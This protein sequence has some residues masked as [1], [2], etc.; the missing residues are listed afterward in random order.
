MGMSFSVYV[1]PMAVCQV[2]KI[3][4]VFEDQI[5]PNTECEQHKLTDN[6][7]PSCGTAASTHSY[8]LEV[9]PD[10]QDMAIELDDALWEISRE[11][12]LRD[13]AYHVPNKKRAGESLRTTMFSIGADTAA[14]TDLP[15][16]EETAWFKSAFEAE[17]KILE[18]AYG[19]EN[20]E[21][22]WGVYPLYS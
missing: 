20:V 5:C 21:I 19:S 4:T 7:C 18:K 9:N 1:G 17:I 22:K 6:F 2:K 3:P 12:S 8:T 15:V 11:S 13:Q 10:F 14:V 16:A